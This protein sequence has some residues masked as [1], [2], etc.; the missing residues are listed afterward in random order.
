MSPRMSCAVVMSAIFLGLLIL[1]EFTINL[2][3]GLGVPNGGDFLRITSI[4]FIYGMGIHLGWGQCYQW[5]N[6]EPEK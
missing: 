5:Y 1:L 2:A 3:F 6:G 4:A